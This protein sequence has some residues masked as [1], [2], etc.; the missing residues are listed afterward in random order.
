M[1]SGVFF[2][3]VSF[4]LKNGLERISKG[5]MMGLLGLILVILVQGLI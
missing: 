1:D 4:G 2:F 5:M 3:V